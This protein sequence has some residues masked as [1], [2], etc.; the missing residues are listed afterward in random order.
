MATKYQILWLVFLFNLLSGTLNATELNYN[1]TSMKG[2]AR[3]YGF[4]LGQDFS[5]SRI[6]TKYPELAHNILLVNSEFNSSFPNIKSKLR[7][8]LISAMKQKLFNKIDNNLKKQLQVNLGDQIITKEIA[9]IFLQQVKKRAEGNIESP[10]LEYL[11]L[12]KY[13]SF[14]VNEFL[15]GYRQT[16]KTEGHKKAQGLKLVLQA[17]KSWK[18]K[19]GNRPH[20]VQKWVSANGTGLEMMHL[21]IRDVEGY[22]PSNK[23]IESF[24]SSGE[25]KDSIPNGAKYINS[26]V[27]SLEKRKGYWVEMA[28]RQERAGF[29]LYNRSVMY[30]LFFRGKVIGFMCQASSPIDNQ[31]VADETYKKIKPLCQQVLNSFV[32]LQAY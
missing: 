17:P 1:K 3:A 22:T 25:V 28:M 10:T 15:E 14:P 29:K 21:D 9:Q 26:G 5:L 31:A 13:L 24:V 8:Q 7:N 4:I 12:V 2:L 32:L 30:Q 20:I 27:F 18:A 16:F 19:E 6:R 23:E 11:L